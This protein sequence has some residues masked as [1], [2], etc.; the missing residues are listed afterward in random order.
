MK[1]SILIFVV[2]GLIGCGGVM[3]NQPANPYIY[4]AVDHNGGAPVYKTSAGTPLTRDEFVSYIKSSVDPKLLLVFHPANDSSNRWQI[5]RSVDGD[6]FVF[7]KDVFMPSA[8]TCSIYKSGIDYFLKTGSYV[9]EVGDSLYAL[10]D[11]Y[12]GP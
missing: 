10:H 6:N 5:S 8:S 4:F 2:F 1:F 11:A 3:P 12:W 7:T 9:P